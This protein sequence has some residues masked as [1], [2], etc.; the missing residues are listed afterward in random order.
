MSKRGQVTIFLVIGII[1]LLLSAG[2]FFIFSKIKTAPLEVEAKEAQKIPGVRGTLQAFV[3]NCIKETIDP[4]IYL[5]AIQGGVI[6]PEEDSLILLTDYGMVNYAWINGA[7]S[8]S[9]EK[10]EKDLET[11]L[12]NYVDFCLEDFETFTKQNIIVEVDYEKIE[13]ETTIR[14][15]FVNTEMQL[16]LTVTLPNNDTLE[17]KAFAAQVRSNFGKLFFEVER[18]KF[19]HLAS[20]ELLKLPYQPL[21]LPYDESVTIYSLTEK[22]GGTPLSFMFAVRNDFPENEPPLLHFIPDQTFRASDRWQKVLTA[23]DPN[24]DVLEFLSDSDLVPIQNDGTID[25]EI[26]SA[27]EFKVTFTVKDGRG[28]EDQQEVAITILKAR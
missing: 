18:F 28:G 7:S 1:I 22:T 3:E 8:L 24:N 25:V 12:E 21:I 13:A 26:V 20:S 17:M 4:A 10:M 16:P 19:P 15:S 23:E 9:K 14:E 2:F 27:G 6:Y 11:Y 5:L